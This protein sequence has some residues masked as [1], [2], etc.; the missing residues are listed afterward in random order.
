MRA[1]SS[2]R[3]VTFALSE[4]EEHRH[5]DAR[6]AETTTVRKEPPSFARN[7]FPEFH[8]PPGIET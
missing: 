2:H 7:I 4:Q 3:P 6:T 5:T 8:V 1:P